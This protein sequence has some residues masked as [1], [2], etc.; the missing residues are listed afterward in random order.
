MTIGRLTRRQFVAASAGTILAWPLAA[1]AQQRPLPVVGVLNMQTPE[2]DA[3][4][5]VAIRQGLQEAGFVEG[6]NV[7]I[8]QR[9]ANGQIDRLPALA[10]ELV[11]RPV[12]VIF[13]NT[14]P[15]AHAAKAATATIPIVFVT[16]VDPVEV[17]LVASLNRPGGNVTGV[18][19]LVNKLVAK[20]LELLGEVVAKS[21]PIGMLADGRNP[22]TA[23]DVRDAQAAASALGRSLHVE[24]VTNAGDIDAA[25]AALVQQRIVALFVAPQANFRIWR[26]QV[27]ALA[28]RHDL[29][30]SFPSSDYVAAGGLMSYGPNQNE[31]YRQAGTYTGRILKGEQPAV[32]PV[33]QSTKFEFAINLK[34]ARALRVTIPP[35]M[36][37]FATEVIE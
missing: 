29:P 2:S 16:G 36:L 9:F 1:R 4:R 33:M 3:P 12:T 8:E 10:A 20:R 34:T 18:T 21:G 32:L 17:G 35:A 30:T 11:R 37:T 27:L 6:R 28:A 14:T 13:A 22:N 19:F 24:M 5:M 31:S 7:A 26:Q 23:S 25:V 15:P